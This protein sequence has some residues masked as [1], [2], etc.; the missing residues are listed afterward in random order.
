MFGGR[1]DEQ[2]S[3]RVMDY[4]FD[5]GI[6]YFDTAEMYGNG[7]SERTVGNWMR[8]RRCRDKMTVLTKFWASDPPTWGNRDYIR[9]ALDASL[10]R[11]GTDYIDIYMMHFPDPKTPIGETLATLTEEINAGRIRTI[12]FSNF[13]ASQLEEALEASASGGHARFEVQQPE[14]SLVMQPTPVIRHPVGSSYP[15]GLYETEDY[16]FPICAREDIASTIYS[17]LGGG[18]LSGQ[19]ARGAPPPEGSRLSVR[20]DYDR[21][22][23]ERNFKIMDRI[24]AKADEVNMSVY[25]LAMAWAMTHPAVTSAIIGARTTDH[26]DDALRAS[27]IELGPDL[28]AEMTGWTR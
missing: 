4:A 10:Y 1:L 6:T 11:L 13:Y 19:Y 12:G 3:F 20:P 18:F 25:N 21:A 8:Q 28:R 26:I 27:E 17:P 15:L 16:L 5:K 2:E 7:T 22:L 9:K 14:Y 23:T 24:R